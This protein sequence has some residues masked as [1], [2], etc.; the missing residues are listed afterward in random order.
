MSAVPLRRRL[1]GRLV[2]RGTWVEREELVAGLSSSVPALEDAL[3]DLVLEGLAEFRQA[4]GYRLAGT[5]LAREAARLL[6]RNRV[7][8]GVA[9]RQ[10]GH[11]YRVGVAERRGSTGLVMFELAMPMPEPGPDALAGHL[12]QVDAVLAFAGSDFSMGS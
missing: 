2:Q 3:A 9:G 10:V 6:V 4:V 1:L 12:K 11:E 8:R 5:E 7:Q